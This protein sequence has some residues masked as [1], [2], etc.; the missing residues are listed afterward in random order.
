M[1]RLANVLAALR[2]ETKA[3]P[4]SDLV[5]TT[6]LPTISPAQI[7]AAIS[8]A[9]R[10]SSIVSAALD[11]TARNFAE[12]SLVALRGGEPDP[13][14]PLS[15]AFARP[16]P[17]HSQ[18]YFWKRVAYKLMTDEGGVFIV[19]ALDGAG[20]IASLWVRG[21]TS[22]LP[23][24]SETDYISG[25]KMRRGGVW[26]RMDESQYRV[27]WH[28]EA[29]PDDADEFRSWTPLAAIRKEIRTN[30]AAGLWLDYTLQNMGRLTKL[31]G[32]DHP[33][34]TPE[35][36]REMQDEV[37]EAWAGPHNSGKIGVAAGRLSAI[38]LGM[39]FSDLDFG[40][41]TDR[42]EIAVARAFGIPAEL[43]QTLATAKQGEGL[44]GNAY[45]EKSL[46]AYDNRIIPLWSDVAE[47][48]GTFLGPLYGLDPEDV[49]FDYANLPALS[50]RRLVM[51]ETVAKMS[52]YIEPN[53]GRELLGLEP[54]PWGDVPPAQLQLLTRFSPE[55]KSETKAVPLDVKAAKAR[56]NDIKAASQETAYARAAA[57][58]FAAE[59]KAYE[60]GE[61]EP[62]KE[63]RWADAFGGLI[64]KTLGQAALD[65]WRDLAASKAEEAF[66]LLDPRVIDAALSRT[67]ALAGQ[68]STTTRKKL[69]AA[70]AKGLEEG[71]G[72]D[73]LKDYVI[74]TVFSGAATEYRALMI[75]RTETIGALNAG[76]LTGARAVKDDL[77]LKV[78]K[79]WVTA[80]DG[81]VRPEH[82]EAEAEGP[83]PVDE[84][85]AVGAM[86]PG[87]FGDAGLDINCRCTLVYE[88]E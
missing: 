27:V 36:A 8:G 63:S 17:F 14:H 86:A 26:Q 76:Q 52:A 12:P 38:D 75:A 65:V 80:G 32:V 79:S 54:K 30:A 22:I 58:V 51:A 47:S 72:P 7:D 56:E 44:S 60:S 77:G 43:L 71:L 68:V 48:V 4:G 16:T 25:Y 20:E 21:S 10:I 31:L 19:A 64:L 61:T 3:V 6:D 67:Q 42:T 69:N 13:S 49:A 74:E 45:R 46:I 35:V 81:D 82:A 33:G 40:A 83:I 66:D 78:M 29:S 41:L 62:V 87:E 5:V 57:K 11:W 39:S 73:E 28:R 18:T 53:E 37:N 88:V 55:E 15:R 50:N 84:P 85:F 23:I 1:G 59:R 2:G 24:T 70:I 9:A 34:M